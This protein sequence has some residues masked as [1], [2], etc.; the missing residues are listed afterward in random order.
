[1][2]YSINFTVPSKAEAKARV[3]SEMDSIVASQPIHAKDR[4]PVIAIAESFIDLLRD[5][6][7]KDV[8]VQISGYLAYDGYSFDPTNPN[9]TTAS[10]SAIA[11]SV[12]RA[13]VATDADVG[14]AAEAEDRAADDG[15][16]PKA[17]NDDS[18]AEH[19]PAEN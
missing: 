9:L 7:S 2:S 18:D 17:A 13:A 14:E 5:D 1:V 19:T 16:P 6:E 4:G 11:Y 12:P 3:A 8:Q 10:V 15:A